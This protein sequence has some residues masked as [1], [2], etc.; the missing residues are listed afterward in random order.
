MILHPA[1]IVLPQPTGTMTTPEEARTHSPILTQLMDRP[2]LSRYISPVT[3]TRRFLTSTQQPSVDQKKNADT[4]FSVSNWLPLSRRCSLLTQRI[5]HTGDY[6]L[7]KRHPIS[8]TLNKV[9]AT[10]FGE[11]PLLP[12]RQYYLPCGIKGWHQRKFGFESARSYRHKV[13]RLRC[14]ARLFILP[15]V[16]PDSRIKTFSN[17]T[18]SSY[19]A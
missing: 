9:R 17:T 19:E 5:A 11:A 15:S 6:R 14:I 1:T 18:T 13:S 8:Y 16:Y 10:I 3:F 12:S 2:S 4:T 7:N